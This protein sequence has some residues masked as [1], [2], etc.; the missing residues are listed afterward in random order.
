MPFMHKLSRR[1]ASNRVWF[2]AALAGVVA[3]S[4]TPTDGLGATLVHLSVRPRQVAL[5]PAQQQQFLAYGET[6]SG[7][8]MPVQVMW[9][10]SG[11]TIDQNGVFTADIA[12]GAYEVTAT[13]PLNRSIADTSRVTVDAGPPNPVDSAALD[14]VVLR[15]ANPTIVLGDSVTFVAVGYTAAGDTTTV[16][17]TWSA[18]DG[19]IRGNGKG[20]ADYKPTKP[21]KHTVR[22]S[23]GSLGDSTTVTVDS[24][25]T[26]DPTPPNVA[27]VTLT[28]ASA[29]VLVGRTLQLNAT[30]QDSAGDTLTGRSITWAS[31][32][33]GVATVSGAGLVNAVSLGSATITATSEGRSGTA[34]VTVTSVPVASVSVAPASPTLYVGQSVQLIATM[35][36][37]TGKTLTGRTVTWA[38]SASAVATVDNTGMVHGA[39][40][41]TATVIAT[42][43]GKSG[44]S[45]VT[46]TPVP[47]ASVRVTPASATVGVGQTVRLT[48]TPLDSAGN[49]L[50]GRAVTWG[51]SAPATA[52]VDAT[53]LVT[54]QA[55][56]TAAITAAVEGKAGS[57]AVTGQSS[58]F[59]TPDVVNDA[60]FEATWDGFTNGS[61]GDPVAH[62]GCTIGFDAAQQHHG[63][64]SVK[65]TWSEPQSGNTGAPMWKALGSGYDRLW[66][67]VYFRLASGWSISSVQKWIRF[68]APG[69]GANL[70]GLYLLSD[71]IGFNFDQ[72]ASAVAAVIIPK[73]SLTTDTWHYIEVDYERNGDALPSAA[74]WLD[75]VQL[76]R[77]D[78][79]D[80][81]YGGTYLTWSGGRLYPQGSRGSSLQLGTMEMTGTLNANA[82]SASGTMWLDYVAVSSLG[83]IGP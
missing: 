40:S 48:A 29:Q 78:G 67:R 50:A 62:Q 7:D 46:V 14:S 11:G 37:S 80:P 18:S 70:G 17:V 55:V 31:S 27:S 82:G 8:T 10:A 65:Y 66:I 68:S 74:F 60:D 47:V 33:T 12:P 1:L 63:A 73:A 56:G 79:P 53:G 83:R 36:D 35:K 20:K 38:S 44:T 30:V 4:D 77:P 45:S 52:T 28:P 43:E 9:A 32:A 75:G 2:L 76:S 21:G 16:D 42:S 51:T 15:P 34:T 64:Y 57:A 61:G 25:V 59:A 23:A 54:V 69:Y 72:E 6:L 3:C 19:V 5:Q 24:S 81:V 71:G 41:G 39:G 58:G 13:A 26:S 49:A 22:G